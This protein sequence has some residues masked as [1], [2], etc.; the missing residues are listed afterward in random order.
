MHFDNLQPG[1]TA[2]V[3]RADDDEDDDEQECC[4]PKGATS[5]GQQIQ[6]KF[7]EERKIFLW[8]AV[9]DASAKD[10]TEKLLYLEAAAPGQPITFYLNSPGGSI[11]AGM[12]VYDTMKLISSPIT[13][14]VTGMAASMGSI[15]LSGARKGRRLL[16]PHSRVLIHQ[17]LISGRMVGPATDINIQAKEMEKLR[18]E[19]NQILADASG[20]PLEKINQDT[21]RDFYLNAQEA[22]AYGLADR[23]VDQA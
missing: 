22:I 16:Y 6:R 17:P 2:P 7:L 12:A 4:S 11:T 21:D 3:P 20:Q 14:V 18:S 10:I 19:L 8:G 23:I 1:L 5:V 13:V 15:L 9:T